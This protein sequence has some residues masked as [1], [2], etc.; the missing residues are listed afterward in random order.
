MNKFGLSCFK[1]SFVEYISGSDGAKNHIKFTLA[2]E[3]A[4]ALKLQKM[5]DERIA[6]AVAQAQTLAQIQAASAAPAA[7]A[8]AAPAGLMSRVFGF[9]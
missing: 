3:K 1:Q 2:V 6:Q 5:E 7:P 9:D 8:P 4:K